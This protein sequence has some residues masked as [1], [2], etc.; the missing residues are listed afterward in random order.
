MKTN[1][2]H[3]T[4]MGTEQLLEINGGGF[5]YDVGRVIRFIG[6]SGPNWSMVSYA[7]FDWKL[8]KMLTDLEN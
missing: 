5:A 8:N 4:P 6:L 3:F 7:V 1:I 2:E